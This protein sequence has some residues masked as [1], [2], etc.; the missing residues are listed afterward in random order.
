MNDLIRGALA[1]C[2]ATVPMTIAME[3]VR[4]SLPSYERYQLPPKTITTNV[5]R[6]FGLNRHLDGPSRDAVTGLAHFGF[7][8][9][10]GAL[11]PPLRRSVPLPGALLGPM[12]GLAVWASHYLGVLPQA[13]LIPSARWA[14]RRR[15]A[16]MII[17]HL[18][19]GYALA[20]T[21]A[22]LEGQPQSEAK[23]LRPGRA[24]TS[25]R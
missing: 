11:Y 18:V 2:V 19:W 7:G 3:S 22:A 4:R 10:A 17:A 1:G 25:W 5:A 8:T 24:Q 9:A 14:P 21:S 20:A 6:A 15:N 12:Y 23:A 16:M 13:K